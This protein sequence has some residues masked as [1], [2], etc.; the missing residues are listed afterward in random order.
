MNVPVS[1]TVYDKTSQAGIQYALFP[2][3]SGNS[4]VYEDP[5]DTAS[6]VFSKIRI[7]ATTVARTVFNPGLVGFSNQ[8]D[9]RGNPIVVS[10]GESKVYDLSQSK[11]ISAASPVFALSMDRSDL[12]TKVY[13]F[14][15][16][17]G[18][19]NGDGLTDIGIIHLKEPTWYFAM[20]T[21]TVP[22]VIEQ[23]KNG[24]GGTYTLEYDNSTK[25]D[26]NGGDNIPDLS[27]NY[28]VCTKITLDDGLGNTIL[29][30]YSYKNG[31]S[32]SAFINGKK[33][34][35]RSDLRILQ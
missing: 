23:I 24:I 1:T 25:F 16:I 33:K 21:G 35:M 12:M 15:W 14:Q 10:D 7:T 29:K 27:I 18:D 3:V 22:D 8:F 13:P 2:E 6:V 19:Y 34:R 20:S 4:I 31:V 17:Q 28:R 9:H 30:N 26:N 32:F 5:T 11:I